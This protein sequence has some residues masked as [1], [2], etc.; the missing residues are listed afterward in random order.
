MINTSVV[1][2]VSTFI[3][4]CKE[5]FL[6]TPTNRGL[7]LDIHSYNISS[8]VVA[9]QIFFMFTPSPENMIPF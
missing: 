4:P 7:V 9:T 6:F 3:Y 1:N 5:V 2:M 8:W